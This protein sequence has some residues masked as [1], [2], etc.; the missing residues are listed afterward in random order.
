ELGA[1]I[2][3]IAAAWRAMADD[4]KKGNLGGPVGDGPRAAMFRR[5]AEAMQ[6]LHTTVN[7]TFEKSKEARGKSRNLLDELTVLANSRKGL[8]EEGQAKF[9]EISSRLS[10]D[11]AAIN[12]ITALPLIEKT[13]VIDVKSIGASVSSQDEAF[14]KSLFES[15]RRLKE[16]RRGV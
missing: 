13:G 16:E 6:S 10:A 8:T 2:V 5:A 7:D 9:A 1:K 15:A 4:E 12:Q 11:F 3:R 14:T